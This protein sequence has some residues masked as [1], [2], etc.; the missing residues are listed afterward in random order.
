MREVFFEV[1]LRATCVALAALRFHL[2]QFHPADLPGDGLGQLA[3]KFDAPYPLVGR[4]VLAG[5]RE[6]AAGQFVAAL[7]FM[8]QDQIGLGH[9]QAHRVG[10]WHHGHFHHRRVLDQRAFQLE[11]ADA[12]V[13]SLEH[14]VGAADEGDV[15]LFVDLRGVA[16]AVVAVAHHFGGLFRAVLVAQHQAERAHIQRQGHFAFVTRHAIRVEHG[17]PVARQRTAHGPRLEPLARRVADQG[18]GFRLAETVAQQ[19]APGMQDLLDDLRV[20]RLTGA[21]QFAQAQACLVAG[22][23]FLD[24]HAPHG[25]RRAQAGDA[26]AFQHAE[27]GLRAEA[28]GVVDKDAGTGIPWCEEATPGVLGPARG[29]NVQV[30]VAR[31]QADPVHG[32]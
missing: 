25:R 1:F 24:Q 2:P 5:E 22:Q 32:R 18:G 6:D 29:R 16:G 26:V 17:H 15:A 30:Q 13:G 10:A 9:C 14:V 31:L 23:V 3:D 4:Q 11:G 27:Q 7:G 28:C 20:E 21:H 12:V 8:G 19:Q